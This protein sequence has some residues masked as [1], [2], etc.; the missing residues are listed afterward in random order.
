MEDW[1]SKIDTAIAME[2]IRQVEKKE[3]IELGLTFDQ[4]KKLIDNN[5]RLLPRSSAIW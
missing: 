4:V 2:K 3:D 1:R 5:V